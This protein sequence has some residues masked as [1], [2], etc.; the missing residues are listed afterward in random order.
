MKIT[1]KIRMALTNHCCADI[2][3]GWPLLLNGNVKKLKKV[4]T[5]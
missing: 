5:I 4:Y 3:T 1:L 2:K